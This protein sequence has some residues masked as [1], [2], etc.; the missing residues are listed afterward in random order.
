MSEI[1][2]WW[3]AL[4]S[5]VPAIVTESPRVDPRGM[6]TTA[7]PVSG[8]TDSVADPLSVVTVTAV[9]RGSSGRIGTVTV[10]SLMLAGDAST[11]LMPWP[12]GSVY[13]ALTQEVRATPSIAEYG[14]RAG[15]TGPKMSAYPAELVAQSRRSPGYQA[16][17][18]GTLAPPAVS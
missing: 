5:R 14:P 17:V 15:S 8:F 11:M 7:T 3:L 13:G 9:T 4:V 2:T 16:T 6:P 1:P 10:T 18:C 12:L